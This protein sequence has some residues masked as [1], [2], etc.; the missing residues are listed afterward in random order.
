MGD[1]IRNLP[2]LD[3]QRWI[4]S[5]MT[6][7]TI[8][9]NSSVKYSVDQHRFPWDV[10]THRLENR[11]VSWSLNPDNKEH[12]ALRDFGRLIHNKLEDLDEERNRLC[13][14]YDVDP[15]ET[16]QAY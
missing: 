13:N 12:P 15:V 7:N 5:L 14:S 10:D 16:T 11:V 8:L 3:W 9:A 1:Y 6:N 4:D 2:D